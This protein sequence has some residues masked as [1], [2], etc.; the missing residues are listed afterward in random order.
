M[1]VDPGFVHHR[2]IEAL[3]GKEGVDVI[4]SHVRQI[5]MELPDHVRQLQIDHIYARQLLSYCT[6]G[7]IPSLSRLIAEGDEPCFAASS[8]TR[9]LPGSLL[10]SVRP[11]GCYRAERPM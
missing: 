8:K 1:A 7:R 5:P 9:P 3:L 6:Q 2:K 11:H 4:N 10:M